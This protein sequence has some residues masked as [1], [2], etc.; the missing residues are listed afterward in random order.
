MPNRLADETSPYL[1]QH[2]HNPVDWYPWGEEAFAR[3]RAEDKPILLSVG[4]SACHW[5]HVMERESFEN[6]A[7]AALMNELFVN[8]KVDREERPDVDAVYMN[9]V[10]TLTGRGGWPMTVFLT[11][12]GRPFF[13][14]TYYP[15]EDRQGMP[16]FPRLLRALADKYRIDPNEIERAAS[17]ITEHLQQLRAF[18]DSGDLAPEILDH[19]ARALAQSFD[20][21]NG[22]FGGAP[23]FPAAMAMDFLLRHY[24]RS[25]EQRSLDM[26]TFTLTKMAQGGIYDQLGGGFHRYSVDNVWLVPHFEKMLYDNALLARTYLHAWQITGE[27]LFRRVV[28]ETLDYALREL[29][30]PSGAFYSTQDADSE[31]VEGKFFVW[32]PEQIEAVVGEEAARVFGAAYGVTAHGNFEHAT[33]LNLPRPLTT[34][35]ANL[36]LTLDALNASLAESRR[37]LFAAREERVHPG[38]DEKTLAAWNGMLLRALAEAALVLD[39][40]DY[41]AAAVA[42]A[43]FL[44]RELMRDSRLLRTWKEGRAKLAG[45]LEDYALVIDGL[46]HVHELTFGARWLEQAIALADTMLDL[47]WDDTIAGFYDTARDGEAL[48]IR[49][50]DPLDNATPAGN[51]V[52]ASVL[53]RL[54]VITGRDHYRERAEATL[55]AQREGMARY[56]T[57]FGEA[58]QALDFAL[59]PTVEVAL[60]GEP[61][62][63]G[64]QALQRAVYEHFRPNKVVLGRAPADRSL[65]ALSPL[66]E[67]RDQRDGRP[68]AYVCEHYACQAPTTDPAELRRQ[69]AAVGA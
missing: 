23:K 10:Q 51:S 37:R 7:I 30:D 6:P 47:F 36:G 18:G 53:L 39:R 67:A 46:L 31:G 26:V 27:P 61:D 65:E 22:G 64:T 48:I 41:R 14:G 24:L 68:T 5:C 1:L 25:G 19:A 69:L 49:P 13:G 12:D 55:A 58:L 15:P 11:P 20:S 40:V 29:T 50:R 33:I 32:T 44:L 8:I 28:E 35:A 54:A 43:G 66:L 16:G 59:T 9:A 2:A 63:V 21:A 17:G 62:A 38:R 57:A 60:V 3:A 34:V 45:Y 4:Y 56:P 52:A 42:N